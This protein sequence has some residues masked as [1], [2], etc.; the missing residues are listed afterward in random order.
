MGDVIIL[1]KVFVED[2][3]KFED[4]KKRIELLTPDKMEDEEI[5]FGIKSIKLTK[6]VPDEGGAQEEFEAKLLGIEGVRDIELILATR[7]L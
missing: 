2:P 1:Y 6:V 3:E 5:G 4:V 7:S